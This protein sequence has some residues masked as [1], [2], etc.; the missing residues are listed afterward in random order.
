MVLN[1]LSTA[2]MVRLGHVYDNWMIN[3]ALT[4]RKLVRR[5]VR[6]LEEAAGAN[7]AQA[8]LALRQARRIARP[9]S[10][11]VRIALIMLLQKTD[12]DSAGAALKNAGGNIRKALKQASSQVGSK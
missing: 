3:V 10:H 5:A 2:V 4:N 1:M 11:A 12:A 9:A 7:A 6:I 8:A